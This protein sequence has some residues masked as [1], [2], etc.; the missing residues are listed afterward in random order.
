MGRRGLQPAPQCRQKRA[1]SGFAV[2]H[3]G[4]VSGMRPR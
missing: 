2:E 4:H 3:S 1:S